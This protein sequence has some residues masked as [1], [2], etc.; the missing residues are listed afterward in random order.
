MSKVLIDSNVLVSIFDKRD[1]WHERS[2]NLIKEISD[3]GFEIVI[4]DLILFESIS[5]VT[6]RFR[7]R[8]LNGD[9]IKSVID[10]LVEFSFGRITW[11][12]EVLR[13]WFVEVIEIVKESN[14]ELNFNDA[15][16]V[17]FCKKYGVNFIASFDRDFD[18]FGFIKRIE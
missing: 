5:V 14:G 17:L 9:E 6:R 10:K 13:I 15:F 11:T 8:G 7:E 12:N 2:L 16:L 1:K 3:K 18:L 4:V